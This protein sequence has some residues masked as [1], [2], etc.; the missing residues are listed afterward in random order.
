MRRTP[1]L[2]CANQEAQAAG[3]K[4]AQVREQ[5]APF[6][7]VVVVAVAVEV[8]GVVGEGVA[9]QLRFVEAMVRCC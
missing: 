4:R 6:A 7:V 2:H 1:E 5:M 9:E 3:S 8:E